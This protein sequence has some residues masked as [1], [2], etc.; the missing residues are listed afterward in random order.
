MSKISEYFRDI[1]NKV[2]AV[3]SVAEAAREKGLDPKNVVEIPIA[4]N[5]A[6]RVTGLLSVKYPQLKNEKLVKR[7][8]DLEKEYGMLDHAVAMKIAEEVAKEKFCK[9]KSHLEAIDA[10]IRVGF[11]Y[12]T[13]GVVSSPLEGFTRFELK[14]TRE[15][16]DYF[17]AFYSGPI[18]SAGG[19]AASFSLLL[20]DH[21]REVFGYAKFD[22]TEQ[23]V[24]RM[25]TEIHDFHERISNLQYLPSQEEIIEF[26]KN[27]PIQIDGDASEDKEVSNYKD[28]ERIDTNF[29]RNGVAL[30][31]A[32][33]ITQKAPKI[34]KILNKL[35][36]KGF[37]L[38]AWD[39]LEDFVEFQKKLHE[40]KKETESSATYIQDLVAGRPVLG[41]PSRSGGFRLRYG[42]TRFSG[43]SSMAMSP[44]TMAVLEDYIAIGTQLRYEGPGKSSAMTPCDSID[45]PIV[46]LKDGSVMKIDSDSKLRKAK[47]KEIVEILH[48]G[49]FLVNYGEYFNRGKKLQ[50]PGYVEEWYAA[51]LAEKL[52]KE[53][54]EKEIMELAEKLVND[55]KTN[56]SFEQAVALS[57][58]YGI[59]F[60]PKFIYF[61]SH[62][63]KELFLCLVDWLAHSKVK[64]G[65]LLFA[66]NTTEKERFAKGKR[67][68]EILGVE[69]EVATE[70]VVLS[71]EDSRALLFNL[72][73]EPNHEGSLDNKINFVIEKINKNEEDVLKIVNGLCRFK[74]K[75]KAGSYIGARMGRPEKAKLR[76]LTGSPHVLFPVGREG[77]R[78]RS[79]QAACE[80][81]SV[82]AEFPIYYCKNCDR[83]TVY[84]KCDKCNQE[85][86]KM[87]FCPECKQKFASDLCPEHKIA[88]PY[89]TKRLDIK[90]HFSNVVE[91]L[92]LLKHEIPALIKGVRGTTS[93]AHTV[94]H[95][96]KGF[97][98][99][100]FNLNVNKDG[101]VRYDVTEQALT[102]FKPKE[103]GTSIEKLRELGY[104]RDIYGKELVNEN[105]LLE[106][107]P[108]DVILPSC[109]ES[110]NEKADEVFVN[111]ANFIDAL[112]VSFYNLKPFYNLKRKEELIGHLI[113]GLA[114]HTSVGIIGRIIG[115][116]A[117][118]GCIASPLWHAAQRR[119]CEGDETCVMLLMDAFINFS[120]EYLP[121]HRG[122]TQD[123]PLVITVKL[124]PAEVDDMVFD[125]DVVWK[126]P[127][128]LYEAAEK[129]KWPWDIKIEQIDDR[130]GKENQYRDF[131]FTHDVE[132]I[133]NAVRYSAYKSIPN[134]AEKVKGQMKLAEIIRAVDTGDVAKLII[135]RHF[136]R[137]IRGNLRKFSQ[138]QFRCVDC[139]KK[140][141]RP[142]LI[143]KCD[144]CGGKIIFTISE[145]SIIKYLEPAL[146]LGREY[147]VP[148][149][150]RQCLELAKKDI[151]SIFGREDEKQE[152]IEKWFS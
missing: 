64:K 131:G 112:L 130:L 75:D 102:H 78:L 61:W 23:E 83:E 19:T 113:V 65:R 56:I 31:V 6:E 8:M 93:E 106:L 60:H 13:V 47:E 79:I 80:V 98:R 10:G 57:R 24:K 115:F 108:L 21:L 22:V 14:K 50:K 12:I 4:K 15:G 127:L 25:A 69:H 17:A 11:A 141:R 147:D 36:E 5:L 70:N 148:E 88:Q 149:Y 27:C 74:I 81:G 90:E 138:Q 140:F 139:N 39:F 126:Y 66:Y 136:I 150:V 114:P 29:L 122:A 145:G 51:E 16:K 26:Y 42:R 151:E 103:I 44:Y 109:Q 143:G 54:K 123:A 128:E 35:R 59:P 71:K 32:E 129:E 97:L 46:K 1:E 48:L 49:D 117:T 84:F 58:E 52:G 125:M 107:M 152:T 43:L 38:S 96:A 82:K 53:Q 68:L 37:K 134:M 111:L 3:Y 72:G 20:I 99:A 62:L 18:R 33:G 119:D 116:S 34:L 89:M 63:N 7:I 92:G 144:E 67:A 95:L 86:T 9:F 146:E 40:E 77:G 104:K 55:W 137:D 132:N 120:R 118:Q 142:P 28:L 76:K 133:N 121:S 124:N 87:Y 110:A 45:G 73:I 135:E 91:N 2:M 94:E 85:T 100:L 101:T 30:I 41:H 105:Q